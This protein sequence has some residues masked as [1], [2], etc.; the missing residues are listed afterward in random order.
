MIE[1]SYKFTE[2]YVYVNEQKICYLEGGIATNSEPILFLH[3]WGVGIEPYQEVLNVLCD[4]YH[5]FAPYLP[6][7]GKSSN[8]IVNFN[9]HEYANVL[10]AFLR[11]LNITKVHLVGHSLGGGIA[12]TIAAEMPHLVETITLVDSTGIPI[13]PV[14]LVLI[15]RAIE[16]TAQTPQMRFPQIIKIFQGFSYNLFFR[17]QNTIQAL[18]MSLEKDLKLLLP[19]IKAPCLLVWGTNDLTTPL[20][21][22][23]E[24][25][26]LIKGSKLIVVD[27]VYH[28][29]SLFHVEKF[30]NIV[31]DFIHS[32]VTKK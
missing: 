20:K 24:F 14:P 11:E 30:T 7:F 9:Y 26:Q 4:R 6:G 5:L 27:G 13:E 29:W 32:T 31:F 22:G 1:V 10:I 18:L 12:A 16:M 19:E 17:T 15:K 28:E 25:L 2:K 23:Q 8:F 3:G 21:A